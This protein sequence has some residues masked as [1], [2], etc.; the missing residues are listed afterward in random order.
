MGLLNILF[1]SRERGREVEA[2]KKLYFKIPI[3]MYVGAIKQGVLTH[4]A[5][6]ITHGNNFDI[7]ELGSA[8][9]Y[10]RF[11][12]YMGTFK[13][14]YADEGWD[15]YYNTLAVREDMPKTCEKKPFV[16][17]NFVDLNADSSEEAD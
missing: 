7:R 13:I 14:Q 2:G 1:G 9:N 5:K 10:F 8:E 12:G 11:A 4:G 17:N 3:P 15:G 6:F 16:V